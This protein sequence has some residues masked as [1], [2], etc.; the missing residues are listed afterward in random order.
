MI[1]AANNPRHT[2]AAI[3][4][5]STFWMVFTDTLDQLCFYLTPQIEGIP[6]YKRLNG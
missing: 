4:Q 6:A 2:P 5:I 3:F 1:C